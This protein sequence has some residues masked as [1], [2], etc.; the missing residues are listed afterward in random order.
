MIEIKNNLDEYINLFKSYGVFQNFINY[1]IR[2]LSPQIYVEKEE[3][4]QCIIFYSSPAFFILG[5]PSEQYNKNVFSLFMKDSWIIASSNAWKQAIED[6]FKDDVTTHPRIQFS[7]SSLNLDHIMYQR[8]NIPTGLSIVPIEK[9][10]IT[11][12]MIFDDV[13]SRFFTQS[14]FIS[15][16]FGFAL[17]D[18]QSVCHGFSITNY[19]IVGHEIELYFRVGYESYQQHRFQGLGTTLCTY[20]IEESFKRGFIPIWDS[21]NEISTHIAKKLGYKEE[22]EWFMYHHL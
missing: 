19:P 4:P 22:K 14:D 2:D 17:V 12:G 20:F 16:G 8:R 18:D 9:K 10:H 1:A 6:H 3:N 11:K 21:A 15:N 5:E 13:I 7:S